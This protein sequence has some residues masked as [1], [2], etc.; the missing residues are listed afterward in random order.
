MESSGKISNIIR[1]DAPRTFFART[2]TGA[3]LDYTEQKHDN[4]QPVPFFT[5]LGQL[6]A[7][8]IKRVLAFTTFLTRVNIIISSTS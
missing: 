2:N 1:T 3:V 5:L 4:K 8:N 7:E 6:L